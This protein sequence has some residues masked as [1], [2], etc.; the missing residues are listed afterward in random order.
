MKGC[1]HAQECERSPGEQ[2]IFI[3]QRWELTD[4][5]WRSCFNHEGF[6]SSR[7]GLLEVLGSRTGQLAV[8]HVMA[9]C[10]WSPMHAGVYGGAGDGIG[11]WTVFRRNYVLQLLSVQM[12]I[13]PQCKCPCLH[14]KI[15][16]LVKTAS[17]VRYF[18]RIW[19]CCISGTISAHTR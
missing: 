6:H 12:I 11:K 5:P 9:W 16:F 4:K 2:L 1:E 13:Q 17:Q 19:S 7:T 18:F 14:L 8:I 15:N 3:F 10:P